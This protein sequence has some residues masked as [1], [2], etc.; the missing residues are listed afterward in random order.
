V[1]P[2]TLLAW[3]RRLVSRRWTYHHRGGRPPISDEIREL[4]RRL[5]RDNPRG[6]HKTIRGELLGLGH[7]VGLG[8]IRRIL[9][10]GRLAPAPRQVRHVM[11]DVPART[12]V[13]G[14]LA[15]DFFHVETVWPRRLYALVVMEIATHRVRLL[16]ATK[17][18]GA[19][20]SQPLEL[21]RESQG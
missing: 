7:R 10:R 11:A 16:C 13:T 14:L 18:P 1:T 2:A 12:R 3:H 17:H 8:T 15:A 21:G 19:V 5:A 9:A 6:G 20:L 4:I